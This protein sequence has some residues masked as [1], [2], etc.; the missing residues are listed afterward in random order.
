MLTAAKNRCD[1]AGV[2]VNLVLAPMAPLPFQ[3]ESFDFIVAHGIWN[4]AHS[5]VEFRAAVAEAA[6]VSCSG[7]RLFLFTFSRNTLP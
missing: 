3:D 2:S 1:A 5:R 7:A 6:R 4:L